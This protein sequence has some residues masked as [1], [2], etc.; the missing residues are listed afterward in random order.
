MYVYS[1]NIR[2]C[3]VTTC[4]VAN[5]VFLIKSYGS[6]IATIPCVVLSFTFIASHSKY[7]PHVTPLEFCRMSWSSVGQSLKITA[8]AT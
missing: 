6:Y 8:L 2:K 4:M 5:M 3:I 7:S 1:C